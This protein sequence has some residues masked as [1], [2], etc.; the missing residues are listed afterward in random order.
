MLDSSWKDTSGDS[1]GSWSGTTNDALTVAV[2]PLPSW[3]GAGC[4][5]NDGSMRP[6]R[7]A[8]TKIKVAPEEM[9]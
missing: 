9:S 5:G 7:L 4:S 1:C 2:E 6:N 3:D 8:T